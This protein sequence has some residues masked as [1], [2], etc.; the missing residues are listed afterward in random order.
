MKSML[1]RLMAVLFLF[2]WLPG[3]RA[4][5]V[6]ELTGL[7]QLGPQVLMAFNL[8]DGDGTSNVVS[9]GPLDSDGTFALLGLSGGAAGTPATGLRL[10]DDSFFSEALLRLDGADR[11]RFQFDFTAAPR[12][13]A[14]SPTPFRC[15]CWTR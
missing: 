9:L 3:A 15:S 7:G 2:V 11:L 4:A 8:V 10:A 6:V 5:Y 12:R 1:V 14:G 13:R